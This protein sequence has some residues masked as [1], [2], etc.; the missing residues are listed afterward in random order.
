M[1]SSNGWS[2]EVL[3]GCQATTS[4][5]GHVGCSTIVGLRFEDTPSTNP[6][7]SLTGAKNGRNGRDFA[8]TNIP[9]RHSSNHPGAL[10]GDSLAYLPSTPHVLSRVATKTVITNRKARHDYFVLDT[11]ECWVVP[12]L[13]PRFKSIRNG[14]ANLQDGLRTHRRR[15][16]LAT[17]HARA[18]VRGSRGGEIDPVRKAQAAAPP[19]GDRRDRTRDAEEKGVTLVPLRVYFKDGRLQGWSWP[20][21]AGKARYD[22]RQA[23]AARDSQRDVERDLKE[24]RAAGKA[25]RSHIT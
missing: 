12:A 11:Y 19:Q 8:C 17:R 14:R 6:A 2:R 18:P 9:Y 25:Y 4:G 15:R 24:M 5:N 7:Y 3:A 20:L 10:T 21:P 23:I 13:A 22:K 1:K 16:D